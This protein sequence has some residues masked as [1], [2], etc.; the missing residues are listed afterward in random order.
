M[1]IYFDSLSK[2]T[3]LDKVVNVSKV[4]VLGLEGFGAECE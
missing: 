1:V 4:E 3:H 2:L